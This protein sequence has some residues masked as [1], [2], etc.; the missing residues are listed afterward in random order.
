MRST[1]PQVV[2]SFQRRPTI[3]ANDGVAVAAHQR[4]VHRFGASGA[5]EVGFQIRPEARPTTYVYLLDCYCNL[6]LNEVISL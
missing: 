4:I 2:G 3:A 5:V 6:H 1:D